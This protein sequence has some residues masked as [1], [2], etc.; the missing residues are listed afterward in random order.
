[1]KSDPFLKNLEADPRQT[2]LL[3]KMRLRL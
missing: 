3:K 1:M 2:A